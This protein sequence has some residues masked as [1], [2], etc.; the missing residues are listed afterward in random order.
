MQTHS[1]QIIYKIKNIELTGLLCYTSTVTYLIYVF[2]LF[3]G[4]S[5]LLHKQE[6]MH[7]HSNAD[8]FY[9]LKGKEENGL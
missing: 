9:A 8:V 6:L 4:R 3:A 2:L 5:S 1:W 7:Q